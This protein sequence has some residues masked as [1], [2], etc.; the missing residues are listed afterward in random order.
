MRSIRKLFDEVWLEVMKV[1]FINAMLNTI[2]LFFIVH[3]AFSLFDLPLLWSVYVA[4]AYFVYV[5]IKLVRRVQLERIERLNPELREILRTANDNMDKDN[6]MVRAMFRE[7]MLRM[8]NVSSGS[9]LDK[10][11]LII[12]VIAITCLSMLLATLATFH[13]DLAI[14]G[15]PIVWAQRAWEERFGADD[16]QTAEDPG[17]EDPLAAQIGNRDVAIDFNPSL[18]KINFNKV[19]DPDE[20]A[21]PSE[22][23][24]YDEDVEGVADAPSNQ[25][26]IREAELASQYSQE[27]KQIN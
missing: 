19:S 22:S 12:K 16:E 21:R 3:L 11:H 23:F 26:A 2:I 5:S 20:T 14:F 10:K 17:F 1:I 18:N 25:K 6:L 24:F 4:I 15:S 27:V 9:F 7:L 13:I 8:S